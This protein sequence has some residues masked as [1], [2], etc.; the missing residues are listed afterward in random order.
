M[1]NQKRRSVKSRRFVNAL[2]SNG[3]LNFMYLQSCTSVERHK[4]SVRKACKFSVTANNMVDERNADTVKQ[5]I[6]R[7]GYCN[8]I[9]GRMNTAACMIVRNC[10]HVCLMLYYLFYNISRIICRIVFSTFADNYNIL[11]ITLGIKY[12]NSKGFFGSAE[13]ELRAKFSHIRRVCKAY[14]FRHS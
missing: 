3:F 7:I 10:S 4:T 2:L 6:N 9:I 1:T 5:I 8:I 12:K 14:A 13:K 11:Q